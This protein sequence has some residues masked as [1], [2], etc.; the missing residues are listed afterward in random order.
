[1]TNNDMTAAYMG[2]SAVTKICLGEDVVWPTIPP[3]P[4]YSAMPLTF[5]IISAGTIT[6][7]HNF[8]IPKPI[9]YRKNEGSWTI[10]QNNNNGATTINVEEGDIVEF[11]G[12]NDTYAQSHTIYDTFSGSTAIFNAYGNIMSLVYGDVLTGGTSLSAYAFFNLFAYTKI[13][14]AENLILPAQTLSSYSYGGLFEYCTRLLTGPELPANSVQST[15]YGFM[16][17]GC[18]HLTYIKCTMPTAVEQQSWV[19]G[20]GTTGTFI[21][22]PDA[23]W[24][25]G[26]DGVPEGWT[27]EDA[28]I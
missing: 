19:Q 10:I 2:V 6:Y 15:S 21:K 11:K 23:T 20:V 1:M 27:V 25:T 9:Y 22:H 14:S 26:R 8:P 28:V 4:V 13:T 7:T 16:F 5:E 18:S 17:M 12:N 3:E 24:P